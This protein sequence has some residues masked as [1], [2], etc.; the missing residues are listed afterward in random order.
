MQNAQHRISQPKEQAADR[1]DGV[2]KHIADE[3]C[4]LCHKVVDQHKHVNHKVVCGNQDV[5]DKGKGNH[6]RARYN[7]GCAQ[8][9]AGQVV[10]S[11]HNPVDRRDNG[12]NDEEY[13]DNRAGVKGGVKAVLRCRSGKGGGSLRTL[14]DCGHCKPRRLYCLQSVADSHNCVIGNHRPVYQHIRRRNAQ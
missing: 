11:R 13:P 4:N 14:C 12:N 3:V 2:Y 5:A 1:A 6:E 7:T 10:N 9:A 8:R